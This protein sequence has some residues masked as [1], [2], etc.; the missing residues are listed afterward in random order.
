MAE[1]IVFKQELCFS[2]IKEENEAVK[3]ALKELEIDKDKKT[4]EEYLKENI[5]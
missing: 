3:R 2:K 4:I 1:K 5:K